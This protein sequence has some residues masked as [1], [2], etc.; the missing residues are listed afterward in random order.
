MTRYHGRADYAALSS[1]GPIERLGSLKLG[2]DEDE[3]A[4]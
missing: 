4:W 1:E 3:S 2:W